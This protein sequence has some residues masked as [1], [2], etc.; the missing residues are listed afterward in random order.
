[1]REDKKKF[2]VLS[3]F[4]RPIKRKKDKRTFSIMEFGYR[5]QTYAA[6][7]HLLVVKLWNRIYHGANEEP[8][9]IGDA[10]TSIWD[11]WNDFWSDSPS[12]IIPNLFVG[13]AKNAAD[14]GSLSRLGIQYVVNCTDDLPQFHEG[15]EAAPEYSRIPLSD[16]PNASLIAIMDSIEYVV[17]KVVDKLSRG[18]PV[19][20]HCFMGASRSVAVAT[21]VV[22]RHFSISATEAYGRVRA[23]RSAA[24]I[25][26]SFMRDLLTW[27]Q[28]S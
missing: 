27:E 3:F 23:S 2:P 1:M 21:L 25:N 7:M 19:L 24:K 8:E 15:A 17:S 10:Y 28:Q 26:S 4:F 12:E 9:R 14:A 20:I 13:S 11:K 18:E 5:T 22:M 6:Y 16:V